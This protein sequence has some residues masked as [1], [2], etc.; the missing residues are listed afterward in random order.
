MFLKAR[1][2]KGSMYSS[3]RR[4]KGKPTRSVHVWV[5]DCFARWSEMSL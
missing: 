5:A 3:D 1:S 2:Q 4:I